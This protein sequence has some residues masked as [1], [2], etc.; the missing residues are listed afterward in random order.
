MYSYLPLLFDC[1]NADLLSYEASKDQNDKPNATA[2]MNPFANG[3]PA[4][5]TPL[6]NTQYASTAPGPPFHLH[7]IN[8][9]NM[10]MQ[11]TAFLSAQVAPNTVFGRT[12]SQ[13]FTPTEMAFRDRS[14]MD[15]S[16]G[17]DHTS[18]TTLSSKSR[19]SSTSQ[20]PYSPGQGYEQNVPY[21]ASPKPAYSVSASGAATGF[22]GFASTHEPFVVNNSN[23]LGNVGNEGFND[24]FMMGNEWDLT[25]LNVGTG[26]TPLVDTS[27]DAALESVT[28]GW[29]SAGPSHEE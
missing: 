6:T 3:N 9:I 21:R 20:S 13:D 19:G 28:M 24:I 12:G 11:N 16:G 22:A 4:T 23:S 18:S 29:N 15:L 7:N 26:L 17:T 2:A 5:N 1:F 10:S 8:S 27:W 14:E 25:G